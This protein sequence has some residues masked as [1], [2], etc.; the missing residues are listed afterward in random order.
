[1]MIHDAAAAAAI[2]DGVSH[3]RRCDCSVDD[4][5]GLAV[6]RVEIL[7]DNGRGARAICDFASVVARLRSLL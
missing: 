5:D 6:A 3:A 1:M 4:G 7:H 2:R